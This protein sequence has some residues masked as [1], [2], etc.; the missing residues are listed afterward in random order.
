MGLL[1]SLFGRKKVPYSKNVYL[2]KLI[3]NYDPK[4]GDKVNLWN[5]PKTNEIFVYLP[6]TYAGG[7]LLAKF[8]DT[9]LWKDMEN[10]NYSV[11]SEIIH[12]KKTV[13]VIKIDV[14]HY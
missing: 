10:E 5:K 2:T 3:K 7:G 12:F 6:K 9:N 11:S 14:S 4:K 1:S 13:I 8:N